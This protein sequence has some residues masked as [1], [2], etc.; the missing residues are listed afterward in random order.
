MTETVRDRLGSDGVAH[1]RV[2]F[3]SAGLQLVGDLYRPLAATRD[4][5]AARPRRNGLVVK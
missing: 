1:E 2:T 5:R 3:D 4:E